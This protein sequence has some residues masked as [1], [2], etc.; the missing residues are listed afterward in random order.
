MC[1]LYSNMLAAVIPQLQQV[2]KKYYSIF[3]YACY[4]FFI[5]EVRKQL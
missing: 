1:S 3:L 2:S 4:Q 5:K